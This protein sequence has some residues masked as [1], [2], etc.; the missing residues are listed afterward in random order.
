VLLFVGRIQ[1]LKGADLALRCL[2]ELPEPVTLVV[3]GGP[4][5]A[6]GPAELDRLHSLACT[7]GIA[8]RVRWIKPQPHEALADWYR[9][10]DVC[11]VPSRSESFGLVALEAAACGTPVV[12]ANVGGLRSLVADGET[13]Y[14]VDERTSSAFAAPVAELLGDPAHAAAIGIEAAARSARYNWSITAARLRRVYA[15]L[16][17]RELVS[18]T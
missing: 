2:A 14:L 11:V 18:C 3:V 16:G 1:P 6:E 8:D 13:G 12:A 9:A 7:L 10:A 4:S 15:D 17:A 5:G